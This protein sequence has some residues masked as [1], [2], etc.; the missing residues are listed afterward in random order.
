MTRVVVQSSPASLPQP[1]KLVFADVFRENVPYAWRCLRRLGVA[2]KDVEDVCQEVFLVVHRRLDE[3]QEGS[4]LRAWIYGICV[5]KA[6][7]HRR[8]AYQRRERVEDIPEGAV[9][10]A[11]SDAIDKRRALELLD[12]TLAALDDDKRAVFVL[13]EIEGLTMNEIATAIECPLQTAYS[14]LHAAR[15]HVEAAFVRERAWRSA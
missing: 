13:Y 12:R 5:R 11:Q 10:P 15:K 4:S 2:E 8:L 3:F 7:E 6:S 1:A 9:E 14:R